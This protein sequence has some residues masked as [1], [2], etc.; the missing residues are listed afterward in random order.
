MNIVDNK[1]EHIHAI[2]EDE[3]N[4]SP[5]FK[6]KREEYHNNSDSDIDDKK[7]NIAGGQLM[8]DSN[9]QSGN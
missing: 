9:L 7:I 1:R 8:D 6:L 5:E 4:A 3:D 2:N